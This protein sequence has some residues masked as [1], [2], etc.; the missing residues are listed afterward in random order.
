MIAL[1]QQPTYNSFHICKVV[2]IIVFMKSK[3]CFIKV[4]FVFFIRIFIANTF[5]QVVFSSAGRH[6]G[7]T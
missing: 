1:L 5:M 2:F 3:V 4:P 7:A 6:R